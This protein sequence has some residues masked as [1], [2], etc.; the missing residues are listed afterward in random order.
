MILDI[1]AEEQIP[2]KEKNLSITELYTADEVFTT[3]TMGELTPVLMADG[4]SIG[5]GKAGEMTK[6]L[7]TLHRQYA[8]DHG[9]ALPFP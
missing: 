5:D 2:A 7:Q 1:A 3:G 8:Y 4:R 9:E 6:R